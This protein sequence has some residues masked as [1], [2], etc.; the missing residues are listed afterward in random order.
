MCEDCSEEALATHRCW[1]NRVLLVLLI[2]L[3]LLLLLLLLLKT[4]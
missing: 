1:Y 2:M 3:M 4:Q